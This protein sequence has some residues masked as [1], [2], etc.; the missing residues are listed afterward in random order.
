MG[1][2]FIYDLKTKNLSFI[3]TAVDLKRVGVKNNMF[4][5]KLYDRGLV[6]VDPFDPNLSPEYVMRI[7]QECMIN[8][9]YF[10]RECVRIPDQGNPHGIPYMLNRAMLA[11]AWLFLHGIDNYTTIP[12]QIGKTQSTV[13]ILDWA[14][15]F[16]TTDSEFMFIN[17]VYDKA[18]ENLQRLKDQRDLLP[19][20]LQFKLAY[21]DEGNTIEGTDNVKSLKNPGNGNKIVVKASATSVEKAEKIGRGSTQPINSVLVCG[22]IYKPVF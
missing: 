13:S 18:V 11:S 16:G 10:L 12:R 3:Q 15:L 1:R 14:F 17:M 20:Y 22:D 6:G 21:D 9:W 8:P 7:T 19:K 4:F 5:L 2:K